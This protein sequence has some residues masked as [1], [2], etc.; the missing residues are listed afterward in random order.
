MLNK[1]TK[2]MHVQTL[3]L[4][5]ESDLSVE[6]RPTPAIPANNDL[7][8]SLRRERI[9]REMGIDNKRGSIRASHW[10]DTRRENRR[11]ETVSPSDRYVIAIAVKPTRLRFTRGSQTLFDG[12]MPSG[13]LHV[14]G[15]G[16]RLEADFS[17]PC[18]FLHLFVPVDYLR[19]RNSAASG[20]A[21]ERTL[22]LSDLI[23]RDAV[24]E[25]LARSLIEAGQ[26]YDD[27]LADTIGQAI[28][29]RLLRRRQLRNNGGAGRV[30]PLPKWRL[31]RVQDYI[32]RHAEEGIKLGDLAMAVGLSRTHFA[33][34]FRAATGYSPCQYL[35][36]RRIERAK[37]MLSNNEMPLVE[38]ALSVG[39]QAQAHFSSVFRR[40]T[41][42]SPGQWRRANQARFQI[43]AD[44][45]CP[46]RVSDQSRIGP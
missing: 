12:V 17:A 15:P 3:T 4:D 22:D 2:S 14:T 44:N 24:A 1:R 23:L 6:A 8:G 26:F 21:A 19:R 35:R 41:G 33:S 39:F 32:E 38:I 45:G 29:T 28:V 42:E 13:T 16:Q 43:W 5:S 9:W 11:E 37:E 46:A 25:Q 7:N 36:L 30:T 20:A 18:E 31:K 27:L 10:L 34:Q 40:I